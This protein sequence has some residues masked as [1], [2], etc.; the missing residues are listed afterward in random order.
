MVKALDRIDAYNLFHKGTLTLAKM[1]A[2]G[3]RIDVG[4]LKGKD[5]S[6]SAEIKLLEA[7]MKNDRDVYPKWRRIFGS[8]T[9]IG[10][11]HQ[12]A[13]VVF[14]ALKYESGAKTKTGRE[15][16][17]KGAL[18]KV[19]LPFVKHFLRVEKLKK[20]R[21]TYIRGVLRE[22]QDGFLHPSFDLWTVTTFRGSCRSP[23]V[24]NIPARDQE[25]SEIIRSSFI[26]RKGRVLI[27]NDF[28]ALE[29]RIAASRW[30]DPKMIEYASD[31][32]KD[33]HRD[34]AMELFACSKEQVSKE[35]RQVA[36]NSFV[37]AT[38]YGNYY[39]NDTLRIWELAGLMDY[40]LLMKDGTPVRKWLKSQGI[41]ERGKCIVG[42]QPD[43][44]TYEMHVKRVEEKFFRT[45]PKFAAD[46]N[47]LYE[48]Y[49]QVGRIR[50]MTGFEIEGV[51]SRNDFLN[52]G[53]Q[54]PGFHCLVWTIIQQQRAIEKRRMKSLLVSQV[55]DCSLGDVPTNE[56]QD[57]IGS[58]KEIVEVKLPKAWDWI[59]TPLEIECE[60]A[61]ENWFKKKQWI[62][63]KD[64][65]W[66][67]KA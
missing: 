7:E 42:E 29:F 37:F 65:I 36:K 20:L 57:Y 18:E 48:E 59:V 52:F 64:G 4:Y 35:M 45:F 30:N 31:P 51:L 63:S 54:G 10:S 27:E 9:N 22:V 1:E 17:D 66:G 24:Q 41:K 44:H 40:S 3:I 55:H 47:K 8:S 5:E 46:R 11:R 38:L 67:P 34:M 16:T 23:N 6:V 62:Q 21:G 15:K 50:M 13:K 14:E 60:V 56:V 2:N 53:I 32:T 25:T 58:V 26:P 28:G 43:N 12:L 49:Q 61:E 19:N 39:L 33:I